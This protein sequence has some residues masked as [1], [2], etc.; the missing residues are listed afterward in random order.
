VSTEE[1]KNEEKSL[2]T[3]APLPLL[4][5]SFGELHRQAR[6]LAPSALI[7]KGLRGGNIE[8][9]LANVT[10][11]LAYGREV[12]LGPVASLSGIAVVNGRPFAESQTLAALVR[13]S[14]HCRYLR[15]VESSKTSVT[16][17]TWRVGEPQP[18]RRTFSMA[19]AQAAGLAGRDTY[20]AHPE[21][22]LGARALG[23][24]LRDV[25]PD[26]AKGLGTEAEREDAQ[27]ADAPPP[28]VVEQPAKGV[29]GLKSTLK[30]KA[31]EQKALP[32]ASP[33]FADL[34]RQLE[35]ARK[36]EQLAAARNKAPVSIHD[37]NAEPPEDLILPGQ[38]QPGE[39]G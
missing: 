25:Y 34:D 8:E 9:T 35:A 7:P 23:W 11:V 29:E 20:K 33:S 14:G 32:S 27:Y 39:E 37:P 10:L 36:K 5:Q 6:A 24:L 38:R 12:G 18:E 31:E 15:R 22:M 26:V 17:E 4:A 19:D 2:A 1:K 13:A 28:V 21:R 30:K 3:S 16:W